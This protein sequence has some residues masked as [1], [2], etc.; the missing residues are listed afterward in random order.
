MKMTVSTAK[1]SASG[2]DAIVVVSPEDR[3][4]LHDALDESLNEAIAEAACYIQR[5]RDDTSYGL[6][7]V[8]WLG[9]LLVAWWC[10]W[11]WWFW[12]GWWLCWW[13]CWWW[14]QFD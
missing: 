4:A 6:V 9:S 7:A 3:R 13:C 1:N 10:W 14:Y 2:A 11:Y 5:N 8:C 12:L